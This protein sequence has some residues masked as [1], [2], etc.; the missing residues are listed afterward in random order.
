M[1]PILLSFLLMILGIHAAFAQIIVDRDFKILRGMQQ[2]KNLPAATTTN[3]NTTQNNAS[4]PTEST[5]RVTDGSTNSYSSAITGPSLYVRNTHYFAE[6][7][8]TQEIPEGMA[9]T[10]V[11]WNYTLSQHPLGIEVLLCWNKTEVCQDISLFESGHT[12]MFNGKD[13]LDNFAIH[14]RLGGKGAI[15]PAINGGRN[16][17]IVTYTKMPQ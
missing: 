16:Q 4:T 10:N 2:Q 1:R 13:P 3:N 17:I 11:T 7:P 8:L 12:A 9:I 5:A 15:S 14:Y 6:F